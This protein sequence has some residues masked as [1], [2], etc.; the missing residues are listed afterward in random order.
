MKSL[1]DRADRAYDAYLEQGAEAMKV[2]AIAPWFGSKR[3]LAP[4]IVR[5]LGD[6][7][8][9]WE[10]FCGSMAVLLAKPPCRM[11]TV[12]DLHGDLINLARCIQHQ[13]HG[14]ALYRRL[15]RAWMHEAL[16]DECQDAIDA[17]PVGDEIDSGRAFAYFVSSWLGRNG[18]SGLQRH[19]VGKAF[20]VRYTNNGG[21][22]ATRFQSSIDS[23]PAFRRRL[24]DVTIL[25]RDGFPII[26]RI[27]DAPGTAVYIDSPYLVKAATYEHDFTAADHGRL[28]EALRR[29]QHTRVVVSYYEHPALD[30]LYPGWTRRRFNVSKA[31]AHQGGRGTNEKRAVEA[32]LINGPSL[33][34]ATPLFTGGTR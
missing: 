3:N 17:G 1:S 22:G 2:T 29:F 26:E 4:E 12:N 15:R 14:P 25:K 18:T 19:R 32:L 24:R 20:C 11:E 33:V 27:E 31:M 6:H 13:Q 7:R 34:E 30:D 10:P 21:H 28:A 5:E 9:Y 16:Y 23:I 8:A